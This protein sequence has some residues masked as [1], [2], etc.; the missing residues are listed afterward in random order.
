VQAA[1]VVNKLAS[2]HYI[3]QRLEARK[4]CFLSTRPSGERPVLKRQ[5]ARHASLR[6]KDFDL[7]TR[8]FAASTSILRYDGYRFV[9][10]VID[11]RQVLDD[12]SSALMRLDIVNLCA[13]SPAML[14][15]IS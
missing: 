1:L 14:A 2:G 7:S 12:T 13:R 4:R 3:W 9:R 11:S 5:P 6:S 10:G 15:T 8:P